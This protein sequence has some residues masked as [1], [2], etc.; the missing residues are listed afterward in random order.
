MD[1]NQEC[2]Q[3]IDLF[4]VQLRVFV[5]DEMR[6]YFGDQWWN[7]NVPNPIKVNCKERQEN[8]QSKRFPPIA[9]SSAPDSLYQLG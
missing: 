8:E 1:L 4:E 7:Q 5:Q 6:K 9:T 2:S 3:A